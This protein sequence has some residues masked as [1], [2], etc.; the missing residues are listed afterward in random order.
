MHILY[1][2]YYFSVIFGTH[3]CAVH[4]NIRLLFMYL[5]VFNAYVRCIYVCLSPFSSFSQLGAEPFT[6]HPLGPIWWRRRRK[7]HPFR[8]IH[9][10][11][12]NWR[13]NP[14]PSIRPI[15]AQQ[16]TQKRHCTISHLTDGIWHLIFRVYAWRVHS[17]V[18]D[19][20]F[21]ISHIWLDHI[22]SIH[23]TFPLIRW[24][25]IYSHSNVCKTCN[26]IALHLRMCFG[27]NSFIS[28]DGQFVTDGIFTCICFV[29]SQCMHTHSLHSNV[30]AMP[31]SPTPP[32]HTHTQSRHFGHLSLSYET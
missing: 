17:V 8:F 32:P 28:C 4:N 21:I 2:C 11:M 29:L 19:F 6:P 13:A 3:H 10:C 23:S 18:L 24:S 9:K 7:K 14:L 27:V 1:D 12:P 30:L 31:S 5:H 16:Y 26:C 15:F 22:P 20:A 25:H